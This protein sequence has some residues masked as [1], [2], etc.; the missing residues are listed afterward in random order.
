M[1]KSVLLMKWLHSETNYSSCQHYTTTES[2]RNV[3]FFLSSSNTTWIASIDSLPGIK[4]RTD[5]KLNTFTSTISIY[6]K[7]SFELQKLTSHLV[8][9][10]SVWKPGFQNWLIN[11]NIF[12][13]QVV[14][15]CTGTLTSNQE[16]NLNINCLEIKFKPGCCS[17]VEGS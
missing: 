5:K 11:V 13:D 16:G 7:R 17:D 14:T 1:K 4:L 3:P 12:I 10:F 9:N 8:W 15:S 2:W 6:S